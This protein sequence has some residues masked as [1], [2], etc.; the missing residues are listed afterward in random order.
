MYK[1]LQSEKNRVFEEKQ[2]ADFLK[3]EKQKEYLFKSVLKMD[4]SDLTKKE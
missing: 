1:F 4:V 3:E 2:I